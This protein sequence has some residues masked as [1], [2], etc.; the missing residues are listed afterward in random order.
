MFTCGDIGCVW[1]STR[2]AKSWGF[3]DDGVRAQ[4]RR[5]RQSAM[6]LTGAPSRK[7]TLIHSWVAGD[8]GEKTD[9][10][11]LVIAKAN[12]CTFLWQR[13]MQNSLSLSRINDLTQRAQTEYSS[14]LLSS[15][16]ARPGFRLATR[17]LCEGGG[18]T[19]RFV[20]SHVDSL[21]NDLK[22]YGPKDERFCGSALFLVGARTPGARCR[23]APFICSRR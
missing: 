5:K 15:N 13:S 16:R 8:T 19:S 20:A 14:D 10:D 21:L 11:R 4:G 6:S 2:H 23:F 17:Y 1:R 22:C 3:A 7:R 9:R 12:A 18:D